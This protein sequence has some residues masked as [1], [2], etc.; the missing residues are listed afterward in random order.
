MATFRMPT[1]QHQTFSRAVSQT[2]RTPERNPATSQGFTRAPP[3]EPEV[4]EERDGA[5]GERVV[6]RDPGERLAARLTRGV[7]VA[8]T[9]GEEVAPVEDVVDEEPDAG[10]PHRDPGREVGGGRGVEAEPG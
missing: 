4:D 2:P 1:G 9:A 10:A 7:Q 6:V 3:S 5:G 8:V